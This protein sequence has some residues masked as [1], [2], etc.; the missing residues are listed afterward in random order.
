MSPKL[1]NTHPSSAVVA[2]VL[3]LGARRGGR[4]GSSRAF[5][6]TEL[7]IVIAIIGILIALLLPAIGAAREAGRRIQCANN[8]KQIG[9]AINTF[10]GTNGGFPIGAEMEGGAAWSALILPNLEYSYIYD[11]LTFSEGLGS[12]NSGLADWAMETPNYPPAAIGSKDSTERNVAALETVIP[13]FRCPSAGLPEHV[14]DASVWLPHPWFVAR[15][16]PAS[17][18]GCVSGL[19]A[20]DQGT[21]YGLDGIFI[22]NP[23][24]RNFIVKGGKICVRTKQVTDGLSHT[25]LVGEAVPDAGNNLERENPE[26]NMGRKDHWYIGGDDVDDWEGKDWSEF[27]GSTGVPMNLPKVPEGD[28]KFGAYEVGYSSRHAGG[29]NFVFADGSLHFLSDTINAKTYSALGTRAGGEAA[30]AGY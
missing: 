6:L 15:R 18:L 26:L 25:I 8:L 11:K 23:P 17:Y 22:A 13:V 28:P 7:L 16:V 24:P 20:C 19:A 1:R 14:I 5:T 10:E 9:L 27:L 3:E 21:I 12:G 2:G 29:C 30:A 4:S